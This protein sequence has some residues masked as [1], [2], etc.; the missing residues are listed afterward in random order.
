MGVRTEVLDKM[1]IFDCNKIKEINYTFGCHMAKPVG[2]L[3]IYQGDDFKMLHYK[4]M[5]I[6][7]HMYKQK[8]RGERLSQFNKKF[9]LGIYYLFSEEQ[10]KSIDGPNIVPIRRNDTMLKRYDVEQPTDTFMTTDEYMY[11]LAYRKGRISK[12]ISLLLKQSAIDCEIHRKLHSKEQPVI[13]CMRFDTTTKSEDLAFKPSYLLE[14]KDTLYLRNII[15][16]SRKLQK[17]RIKGLAM[18]LDP[19]TNDIFDFVAFEDNQRLL[20]IGTKISPTE[21]HFLV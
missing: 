8:I 9:G 3:K 14:E 12:N 19:V 10:Q 21:I 18:I 13:Q 7:D 17:I 1:M 4:F 16:K 2:T 20:K 5:G 11:D 15:R 6:K